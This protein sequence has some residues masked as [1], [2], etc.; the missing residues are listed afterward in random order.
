[1][2]GGPG[3][4]SNRYITSLKLFF[5]LIL[6]LSYYSSFTDKNN[7]FIF[8]PIA[9]QS[10]TPYTIPVNPAR[11]VPVGPEIMPIFSLYRGFPKNQIF[12]YDNLIMI[13]KR[14]YI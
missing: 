9:H 13:C 11:T 12:D 5:Y 10:I 8:S 7:S 3:G 1:M 2:E 4:L 14:M 6:S